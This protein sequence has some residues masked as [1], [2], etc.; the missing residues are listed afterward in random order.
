MFYCNSNWTC[1][2]CQLCRLLGIFFNAGFY[3]V[4]VAQHVL[5]WHI[6][7][8]DNRF[9]AHFKYLYYQVVLLLFIAPRTSVL[10][11]VPHICH[12]MWEICFW[13][14]KETKFLDFVGET[15]QNWC[16]SIFLIALQQPHQHCHWWSCRLP[17]LNLWKCSF[18]T[19]VFFNRRN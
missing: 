11:S 13:W 9:I 17:D 7:R 4:R 12:K 18:A 8:K 15:H 10:G 6:S 14:W 2:C 3:T 16:S 1:L 19:E 5:L